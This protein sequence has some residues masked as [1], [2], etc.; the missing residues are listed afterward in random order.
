[1]VWIMMATEETF[2]KY[3][4]WPNNFIPLSLQHTHYLY[5]VKLFLPYTIQLLYISL[6]LFFPFE[7]SCQYYLTGTTVS[8]T[9]Q[10]TPYVK[11]LLHSNKLLYRSGATGDFGIP[12]PYNADT[13]S[14]WAEG[15][16]TS[17]HVVVHGRHNIIFLSPTAETKRK[18]YE[19][20]RL[21]NLVPNLKKVD[22]PYYPTHGE[23][24]PVLVENPIVN[25]LKYPVTGFSPNS[26]KASYSNIR[27]FIRNNM[28]V[29]PH[30]VRVE[31]I[32]NYF[33][34]SCVQK[35]AA[36][37]VF[38]IDSR[39]TDCPWNTHNK[40]LFV[41]AIATSLDF[42]KVPPANLVFLIDN[43]GSMDMPNRL[44]LLK[45]A[46]TMLVKSLRPV[47]RV[48]IVTYGGM[49]G[50][51]LPPTYGSDKDSIL[52]AIDLLEASGSTA[53]SGGIH[54]AYQ[55]ALANPI[56]NSNNRVILATDGDFNVGITAE[57]ELEDLITR[58]RKTGVNLTCLGVGMGNLKDSKIETLARHGNGTY[59]YLD[60]EQEA[61][62]VMVQELTQNLYSVASDV[63]VHIEL[64]PGFIKQYKLIGYENRRGAVYNEKSFLVGGDIGSGF[65]LN[66]LFEITLT[67]SSK[68]FITSNYNQRLGK[69]AMRYVDASQ[70][71]QGQKELNHTIEL[72]Y[73][74][75]AET[76][77]SIQFLTAA[78]IYGSLLKNQEAFKN[79]SYEKVSELV[80]SA[81][82]ATIKEQ[83][84]FLKLVNQT[85]L[86]YN[87]PKQKEKPKP[88]FFKK[89][90]L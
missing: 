39:I 30:A 86:I 83:V 19:R 10:T 70:P 17:V 89:K 16:D 37:E 72:N 35:P 77:K 8:D 64:N 73:L 80:F 78:T 50:I 60:S 34:L 29:P 41:N 90:N 31:E 43:S 12:S 36:N 5:F 85:A 71:I 32:I 57:K 51:H 81:H 7:G 62:K 67:D 52:S 23:T 59:A 82:N 45:S 54:L 22:E 3:T 9:T 27:R 38:A 75:F 21:S 26:N 24:Y 66:A 79:M 2:L 4:N 87:P 42:S 14:V 84:E 55:L 56:P 76:D 49:A 65:A 33:S 47:D 53:G 48:S 11:I 13:I 74:P 68:G 28:M 18:E 88:S 61:E 1:M 69:L 46:F 63:T 40:L 6:V 25:T 58:Y 44:P 20:G 15:F